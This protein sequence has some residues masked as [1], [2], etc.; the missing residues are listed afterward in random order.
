LHETSL[1]DLDLAIQI[2]KAHAA[3]CTW[4][5]DGQKEGVD[6]FIKKQNKQ[7]QILTLVAIIND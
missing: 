7:E 6:F 2:K 1:I 5:L 3:F 4:Y